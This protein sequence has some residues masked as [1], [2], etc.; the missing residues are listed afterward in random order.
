MRSRGKEFLPKAKTRRASVSVVQFI[1]FARGLRKKRGKLKDLPLFLS[2]C[3]VGEM[4]FCRR[5][6]PAGQAQA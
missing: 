6:K 3:E 1:D 4:N 2:L 5:Q